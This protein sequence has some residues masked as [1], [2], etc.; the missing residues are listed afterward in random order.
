M[1]VVL[2]NVLLETRGGAV[3]IGEAQKA[4]RRVGPP[5]MV[6]TATH[7]DM[8]RK[9]PPSPPPVPPPSPARTASLDR[10][11]R[12]VPYQSRIERVDTDRIPVTQ[13]ETARFQ[14]PANLLS[15]EKLSRRT[16]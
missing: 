11:T 1:A 9:D 14:P 5:L 6:N 16:I 3:H 7:Y 15:A 13:D 10:A 4:R 8:S 12:Y 2:E